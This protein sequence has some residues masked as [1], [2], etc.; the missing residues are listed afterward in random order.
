MGK[1]ALMNDSLW[2]SHVVSRMQF[3]HFRLERSLKK[4]THASN[5]PIGVDGNLERYSPIPNIGR[6]YLLD[7]LL[8]IVVF[9][10]PG[11]PMI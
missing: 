3:F 1:A 10:A 7:S 8:A 9:P 5:S 4:F 2:L 6:L 11:S